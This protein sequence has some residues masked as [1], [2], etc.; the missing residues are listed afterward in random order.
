M[1]LDQKYYHFL[2]SLF[3][4]TSQGARNVAKTIGLDDL[5]VVVDVTG[6]TGYDVVFEKCKNQNNKDFI[7]RAL[8]HYKFDFNYKLYT[9]KHDNVKENLLKKK[10]KKNG[11][12]T[13]KEEN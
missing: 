10:F 2:H 13:E 4:S 6:V 11:C 9:G 12:H 1:Q 5:V 3:N 8:Q 7:D